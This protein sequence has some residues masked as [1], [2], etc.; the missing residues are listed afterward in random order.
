MPNH[1]PASAL[2][3]LIT[4]DGSPNIKNGVKVTNLISKHLTGNPVIKITR[5]PRVLRA[6]DTYQLFNRAV[7]SLKAAWN[8]PVGGG[9]KLVFTLK[10]FVTFAAGIILREKAPWK[11]RRPGYSQVDSILTS[12]HISAWERLADSTEKFAVVCADDVVVRH[13]SLLLGQISDLEQ[14]AKSNVLFFA[15]LS[16]PYS[17]EFL[18]NKLGIRHLDAPG[19][20]NFWTSQPFSNTN[21]CYAISRDLAVELLNLIAANPI[22][23][24][25]SIDWLCTQLLRVIGASYFCVK[26]AVIDNGS[27][28]GGASGTLLQER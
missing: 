23:R 19:T 1:T 20:E 21:S 24:T 11:R 12:K 14:I 8:I 5:Q 18:E 16:T 13:E 27:L 25:V 7:L 10:E 28:Q 17:V 3:F 26:D 2:V 6:M 22:L 9:K 4:F 15:D